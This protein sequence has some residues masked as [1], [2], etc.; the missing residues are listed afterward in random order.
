[1]LKKEIGREHRSQGI[2]SYRC[3]DCQRARVERLK[4][5]TRRALGLPPR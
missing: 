5:E 3:V 1:M 2:Y 4:E